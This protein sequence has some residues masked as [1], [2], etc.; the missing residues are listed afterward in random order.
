MAPK[1]KKT[2]EQIAAAAAAGSKKN[3][4]KWSKGKSKDKLNYAVMFDAPTLEKF[5]AEVPKMKLIT[6]FTICERLRINASLA[7]RGIRELHRQGLIRPLGDQHHSHYIYTK[8]AVA[9]A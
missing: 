9:A 6:P 8:P 7:R 1:E 4:K 2:K 5:K 3:K